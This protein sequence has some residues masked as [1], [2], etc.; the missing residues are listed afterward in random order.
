MTSAR[1]GE[2]RPRLRRNT[3]DRELRTQ[4]K[5]ENRGGRIN[6]HPTRGT[7]GPRAGRWPPQ[8]CRRRG[9]EVDG[10]QHITRLDPVLTCGNA[11]GPVRWSGG[12]RRPEP[13]PFSEGSSVAGLHA[14]PTPAVGTQVR[15][16]PHRPRHGAKKTLNQS[17]K[18]L[19]LNCLGRNS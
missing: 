8:R 16:V 11:L 10:R 4:P 3:G 9:R 14:G 13:I 19:Q 12:P 1:R 6:A 15:T 7:T 2:T 5:N 17:H 18:F